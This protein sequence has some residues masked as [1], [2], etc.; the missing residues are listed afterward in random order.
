MNSDIPNDDVS[1]LPQKNVTILEYLL[2]QLSRVIRVQQEAVILPV[3]TTLA[4]EVKVHIHL[5]SR[6]FIFA[7]VNLC[8]LY[9]HFS[10]C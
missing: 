8:S 7:E 10:F 9:M 1:F 5:H 3:I 2:F 4:Q 6:S